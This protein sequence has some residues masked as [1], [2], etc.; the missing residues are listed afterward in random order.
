MFKRVKKVS[1]AQWASTPGEE[2]EAKH[3]FFQLISLVNSFIKK[4]FKCYSTSIEKTT[5]KT[6]QKKKILSREAFKQAH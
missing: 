3:I 6:F 2:F 4:K 1:T 5:L